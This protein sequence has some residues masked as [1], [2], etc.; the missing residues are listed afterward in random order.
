M[1]ASSPRQED[2]I[3]KFEEIGTYP[4]ANRLGIV[5]ALIST[6]TSGSRARRL[7]SAICGI[8]GRGVWRIPRSRFFTARIRNNPAGS[9]CS[10]SATAR[11]Q[12]MTQALQAKYS[13][14]T[15]AM[16]LEPEYSGIRVTP[17]VYSPSAMS[18]S[19]PRR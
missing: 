9:G 12:K 17:S 3:R 4:A 7:V 18:T 16:P 1:M 2:N 13:V 6:R 15:A 10:Q 8:A 11:C 5:D 19:L 14:L